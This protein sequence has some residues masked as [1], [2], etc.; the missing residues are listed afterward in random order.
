MFIDGITSGLAAFHLVD[1]KR[2]QMVQQFAKQP[3]VKREIDYYTSHIGNVKSVD[4]LLKDRRLLTVALSAFQ[5]EAQVDAK[6][7]LRKVLTQDPTDTKALVNQLADG[8]GVASS[9]LTMM[10][11]TWARAYRAATASAFLMA[12]SPDDPWQMMQAPSMPSRG[13]PP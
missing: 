8:G 3:Q 7:L 10:S 1:R 6:G 12:R 5:L 13:A 2:D 4:D 11:L 9:S